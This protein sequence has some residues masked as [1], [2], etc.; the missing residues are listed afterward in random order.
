MTK[1]DVEAILDSLK[2]Y[3]KDLLLGWGLS[4]E[5]K[6]L[7][8]FEQRYMPYT[9]YSGDQSVDHV[10]FRKFLRR[11]NEIYKIDLGDLLL[12]LDVA[13]K[14]HLIE[15]NAL[16]ELVL[17]I[18]ATTNSLDETKQDKSDN[19]LETQSKSI[20]GAINELNAWRSDIAD[21]QL[22]DIAELQNAINELKRK[23][24]AL[25][26]ENDDLRKELAEV[27]LI[28]SAAVVL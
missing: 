3:V 21:P 23:D 5:E 11:L 18:E 8:A 9:Q 12:D 17:K 2:E 13:F 26:Q 4:D 28:A 22:G 20:I 10:L 14:N 25:E 15:Y 27:K 1:H 7:V 6:S 19:S 24:I 16:G